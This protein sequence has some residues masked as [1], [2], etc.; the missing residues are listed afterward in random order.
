MGHKSHRKR[1]SKHVDDMGVEDLEFNTPLA[2]RILDD[3]LD[4]ILP[5]R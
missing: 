1:D 5:F 2:R 3:P 4:Q